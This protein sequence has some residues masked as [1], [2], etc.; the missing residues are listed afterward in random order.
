MEFLSNRKRNRFHVYIR[1][2]IVRMRCERENFDILSKCITFTFLKHFTGCKW[3]KWAPWSNTLVCLRGFG[4]TKL[5][6]VT[7]DDA[8]AYPWGDNLDV[9]WAETFTTSPSACLSSLYMFVFWLFFNK[10]VS[11]FYLKWLPTFCSHFPCTV[12]TFVVL[13]F[14]IG[15]TWNK[16]K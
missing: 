2:C 11:I 6:Q 1:R 15:K 4:Q 9:V 5:H 13:I 14:R 10:Y 7:R 3:K 16:D 12:L 8:L